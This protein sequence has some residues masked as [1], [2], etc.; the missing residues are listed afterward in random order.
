MAKRTLVVLAAVVAV[1][2]VGFSQGGE[3]V[4]LDT[5]AACHTDVAD[6]FGK[7]GHANA[8]EVLKDAGSDGDPECLG[9]HTTGLSDSK[10]VDGAVTCEAC[11]GPGG[12]HVASGDK[13]DINTQVGEADCLNCHTPDWSADFDYE[14]YKAEG[15][16][17]TD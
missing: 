4:G 17:A 2:L 16:H 13:A 1:P 6:S 11:H 7:T 5:C 12:E 9:C 15:I 3:Y 8:L 10:Y 14:T